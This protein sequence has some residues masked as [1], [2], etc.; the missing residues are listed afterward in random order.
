MMLEAHE[1]KVVLCPVAVIAI[2]VGDL[3]LLDDVIALKP[4]AKAAAPPAL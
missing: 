4:K 1:S 3:S 2:K